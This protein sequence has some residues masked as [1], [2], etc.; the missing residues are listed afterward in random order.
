[1][2]RQLRQQTKWIMLIT[3]LAF[4]ALMV[5]EWG[6]DLSGRSSAQAS[7]GEL[8]RIDGEPVPYDEYLTIYRNIYEQQQRSQEEP[9]TALQNRQIEDAAWEQ[10]ITER[11]IRRELRRRGIRASDEEIRQAARFAPPPELQESEIFL[12]DGRFDIAKYHEFLQSPA[13]DARLL[14]QLEEYYRDLI[15]RSKLYTQVTSGV[16][17]TDGQLWRLF[18]DAQERARVRYL[19]LDPATLVPDAS[20]SVADREIAAHYRANRGDYRQQARATVRVVAL[21]KTPAAADSAAAL[22]RARSA[23]QEILGGGD[24]AEVAARE[25]ADQGSAARGGELGRFTRNQMVPAFDQAVWSLPIGQISEPVLSQFGY[26]L[27]EVQRREGDEAEAR[28]IL[29]PI[30]MGAD[31]EEALI[32]RADSLERLGERVSIEAAAAE[33]GLEVRTAEVT[34]EL[35]FVPGV[36]RVDEGVDWVFEEADVNEVSPVF[37]SPAAF[38]M[39]HLVQRQ[40]ERALSQEEAT[41]LIRSRL[42]AEKKLERTREMGRELIDGIRAGQSLDQ[43]AQAR[44]LEVG[45]TES[46]TRLDFVPG[47]G[48]A[49][50][51]VGASFGL[52]PG[53]VSGLIEAEGR[54]YI[55][56]SIERTEP[57]RELFEQQRDLQRSRVLARLEQ[58]RWAQFLEGLREQADIVDF[59]DEVLRGRG[60]DPPSSRPMIF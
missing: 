36:G 55:I 9:L 15:P 2:M 47:L 26:H 30:E 40:E 54:I 41:P 31:G 46:F 7:G 48:Q 23:R 58:E 14:V 52:A 51:A 3:A 16:V 38:Y 42:I 45:A 4:V 17:V 35:P 56:E 10:L 12:T 22:E 39:I 29:I 59:R 19:T 6:M 34:P 60:Q 28:H 1:M 13:V 57:D 44:N 27:I 20:V 33:F 32:A 37:E 49:N 21:E 8:G 43:A 24:F 53:Q 50:A 5:F 11:L 18:R 25:S